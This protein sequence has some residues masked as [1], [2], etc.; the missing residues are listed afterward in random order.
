MTGRRAASP[1]TWGDKS[2]FRLRVTDKYEPIQP[3]IF[4][5]CIDILRATTV[6]DIGANIGFY[7]LTSTLGE[8]VRQVVGFEAA[9]AS[10]AEFRANVDAN[11]LND[12]V[13]VEQIAVSDE[14]GEAE[15]LM[16]DDTSGINALASTTVHERARYAAEPIT[17][18]TV[19]LDSWYADHGLPPGPI[20]MKVDVEGSEGAVFRG[21]EKL[22]SSRELF[23][24]AEMFEAQRDRDAAVLRDL[25]YERLLRCDNDSYWTNSS[26]LADRWIDVVE[27]AMTNCVLAHR[28]L[29]PP[30]SVPG[31]SSPP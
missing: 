20:G 11:E 29:W 23:I 19:T 2:K 1:F 18:Q 16:L 26:E 7:S 10:A 21:A 30:V 13:T 25:G 27:L 28:K 31:E 8:S 22:L 9:P 14:D 4:L 17:V 24:Q 15:F 6:L 3:W 12:V 5:G